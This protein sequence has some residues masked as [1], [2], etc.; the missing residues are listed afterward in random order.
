MSE[1][2]GG[3]P[4]G[5]AIGFGAGYAA[6]LTAGKRKE[7]STDKEKKRQQMVTMGLLIMVIVGILAFLVLMLYLPF[8]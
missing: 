3:I 1:L 6:G 8:P 5:I 7:P 2:A 4:I